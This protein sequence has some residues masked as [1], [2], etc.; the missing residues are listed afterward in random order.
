M[1]KQS[2]TRTRWLIRSDMP[3][4]LAIE[5]D[6]FDHPWSESDFLAALRQLNHIGLVA[7]RDNRI[8][9]FTIYELHKSRLRV[10]NFAVCVDSRRSDI[11]TQMIQKLIS[12]LSPQ[13]RKE[14]TLEVRETNLPAQLFFKSQGFRAIEVIRDCYED[15]DED[16]F[17]M[18]YRLGENNNS[19]MPISLH[20]RIAAFSGM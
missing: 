6:S 11:G 12:K 19:E 14:I 16:A 1:Q 8:V 15:T 17:V 7:E 18:R 10:L 13:L 9:G 2:N 3:D 5:Y 20:N 4:V